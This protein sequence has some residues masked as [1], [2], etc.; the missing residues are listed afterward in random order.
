MKKF[1]M[2]STLIFSG[3]AVVGAAAAELAGQP[4]TEPTTMLLLGCGLLG[5]AVIGGT[6]FSKK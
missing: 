4:F 6:K 1:M 5:L 3:V 2:F